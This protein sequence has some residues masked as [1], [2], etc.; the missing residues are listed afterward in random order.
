MGISLET[1]TGIRNNNLPPQ[2]VSTHETNGSVRPR[3]DRTQTGS[4]KI[5][6]RSVGVL[7]HEMLGADSEAFAK[8]NTFEKAQI[9]RA[10]SA[11]AQQNINP[12]SQTSTPLS[13]RKIA[14]ASS[15]QSQATHKSFVIENFLSAAGNGDGFITACNLAKIDPDNLDENKR[16][17][18]DQQLLDI[19]S[20]EKHA[21]ITDFGD[22]SALIEKSAEVIRQITLPQKAD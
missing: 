7:S 19:F 16:E 12:L 15:D 3:D 1:M 22:I 2:H 18:A 5:A 8:F 13:D 14:M 4:V 20:N 10:H 9:S 6:Q 17:L 21:T 11:F